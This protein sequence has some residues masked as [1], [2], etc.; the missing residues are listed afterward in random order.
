MSVFNLYEAYNAI[1][2]EVLRLEFEELSE[3]FAGAE[4]LSDEELTNI[5]EESIHEILGEGFEIDEIEEILEEALGIN[6]LDEAR[7][8]PQQ[9][10]ARA[11]RNKAAAAASEKSASAARKSGAAVV[12]KEKRAERVAKVKAS[13]KA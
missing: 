4:D 10:S 1:Y 8:T 12:A 13:V 9:M 6:V 2:D 3:E 5:I 7:M 11:E